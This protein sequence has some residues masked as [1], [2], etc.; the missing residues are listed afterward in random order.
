M[1]H[2]PAWFIQILYNIILCLWANTVGNGCLSSLPPYRDYVGS[3]LQV[4]VLRGSIQ[5]II[6]TYRFT[7]SGRITQWGGCFL[8]EADFEQY[9]VR[10]QVW[11]ESL[12]GCFHLVGSNSPQ[13][14]GDPLRLNGR[15]N[16]TSVPYDEQ[17]TVQ[18]GDVVGFFSN[19]WEGLH[20][21]LDSNSGLQVISVE[22]FTFIFVSRGL[23]LTNERATTGTSAVACGTLSVFSGPALNQTLIG[24]PVITA[25]VGQ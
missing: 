18:A 24:A 25:I 15:C 13:S 22:R 19:Y 20:V 9:Y 4:H 8:P 17:I 10:Y 2:K 12:P 23:N 21:T 16:L 14:S 3:D 6:P 5:A 7:C 1:W 11:R